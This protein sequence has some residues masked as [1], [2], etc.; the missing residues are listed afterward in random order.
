M[1]RL[2][3]ALLLIFIWTGVCFGASAGTVVTSPTKYRFYDG[4]AKVK[5]QITMYTDATGE[6]YDT[7][8]TFGM[9][10]KIKLIYVDH[11][12]TVTDKFD[13]YLLDSD[14]RDWL[15]GDGENFRST[16]IDNN[17]QR[18]PL[19]PEGKYIVMPNVDVYTS[20]TGLGTSKTVY[21]Y[22]IETGD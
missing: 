21:F 7:T 19:T 10:G 13:I 15:F 12:G 8:A 17:N 1:K 9:S 22:I 20:V 2:A 3:L 6:A 18:V 4:S 11:D 14:G 16:N 5:H